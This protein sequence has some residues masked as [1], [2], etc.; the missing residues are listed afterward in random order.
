MKESIVLISSETAEG[1]LILSEAHGTK[2][3]TTS[4]KDSG[5]N[6]SIPSKEIVDTRKAEPNTTKATAKDD[7]KDNEIVVNGS[8][9]IGNSDQAD[10]AQINTSEN[11]IDKPENLSKTFENGT[12]DSSAK[13]V[14]SSN[15][16]ND[17]LGQE[18]STEASTSSIGGT[19]TN[20]SK[21][22]PKEE[23]IHWLDARRFEETK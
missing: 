11:G 6:G 21:A 16:T 9:G 20:D 2:E 8:S 3:L 13:L 17:G 5:A 18:K 22:R 14:D 4:N 15:E 19:E 10:K 7:T 1:T 23:E 12:L